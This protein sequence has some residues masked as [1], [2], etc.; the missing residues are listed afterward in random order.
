MELVTKLS[1]EQHSANELTTKLTQQ[2]D[3][4][5]HLR[6]AVSQDRYVKRKT[7]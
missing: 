7:A 5:G 6:E 3:E 1:T 2:E 4:L